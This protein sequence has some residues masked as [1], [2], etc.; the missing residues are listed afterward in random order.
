MSSRHP[1]DALLAPR[2]VAVVGASPRGNRGSVILGNLKRLGFPGPVHAVNPRY[3]RIGDV[4]CVPS[5]KDLPEVPDFV[6]FAMPAAASVAAV[7]EAADLGVKAGLVIAGGFSESGEAGAALQ[8]DLADIARASGMKLC[9]PNCYGVANLSARFAAYSGGLVDPLVPGN[10]GY[11]LQSGAVTHAIHDTL[12]GRGPGIGAVVTSGNEAAVELSE[13][14]D[15]LVDDPATSVIALFIEGLRDPPAFERAAEKALKAGKPIVALKVGRSERGQKATLAHTGSVAGSDE[16]YDGLFRRHGVIRAE[17]IDHLRETIVLLSSPRRPRGP[18]HAFASISGG[19]TTMLTDLC[20]QAG[21]VTPD[22]AP[23]TRARLQAALPD[24]GAVHNPLDTTGALAENPAILGAVAEAFLADPAVDCF[25][26]AFNTPLGTSAHR[27]RAKV[28]AEAQGKT[29]K[30]LVCLSVAGGGVDPEVVSTLHA[31]GVPFL[32]GAR[33]T[34][35]ALKGQAFFA[36]RRQAFE[37][38]RG[39]LAKGRGLKPPFA[40]KAGVIAE[41]AATTLLSPYGLPFVAQGRAA[42]AAEAAATAGRLGFPVALKI[43]SPDIAHKTEAGGVRLA[44]RDPAEVEAA[45]ADIFASA[46]RHAPQAR[47]DGAL[48][49]CMAPKGLEVLL[50]VTRHGDFGPQLVVGVGGT[51][52]EIIKQAAVRA[53]P[54]A[55]A[56]AEEMIDETILGRLLENFRGSGPFDRDALV[57]AMLALSDAAMDLGPA[58]AAIDVNPFIVLPKG[59]GA[60]AVDALVE[61]G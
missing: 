14:V 10:V 8:R 28:I 56:D 51:F 5:L 26:F 58:L 61:M 13:Y 6:A 44:L 49:Q 7:K 2:S 17:D 23:Q 46:R 59:Q 22:P 36:E 19:L 24:F 39:A 50:G 41:H 32:T 38:D 3:D 33:E 54:I 4:P 16:A 1:L 27:A 20:D 40:L 47:L 53:A 11:V 25:A 37:R 34:I 60:V 18:G 43:D 30:P 29:E 45:F 52:V 55:R 42:S 35:L 57:A 48:V 31:A 12:I 9:G 21:L 15:W